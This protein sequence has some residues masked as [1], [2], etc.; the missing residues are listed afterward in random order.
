VNMVD[1]AIPDEP[2]FRPGFDKRPLDEQLELLPLNKIAGA[3]VS[4]RIL[5]VDP[6]GWGDLER[7][8]RKK[9]V[10]IHEHW[11]REMAVYQ[12]EV[13]YF[14]KML[15]GLRRPKSYV[16]R[17][18]EDAVEHIGA[19][20]THRESNRFLLGSLPKEVVPVVWRPQGDM[21][22]EYFRQ[23]QRTMM[24]PNSPVYTDPSESDGTFTMRAY[25]FP[26]GFEWVR[27]QLARSDNGYAS[28][29]NSI[30]AAIRFKTMQSSILKAIRAQVKRADK[31]P[32][33][34][35][36]REYGERLR[37]FNDACIT[38]IG[39]IAF[40]FLGEEP[41]HTNVFV[42]RT[43]SIVERDIE[44][45]PLV[46]IGKVKND[47]ENPGS[48]T[49]ELRMALTPTEW[50]YYA[51]AGRDTDLMGTP[52]ELK[53][54]DL[55]SYGILETSEASHRNLERK[56]LHEERHDTGEHIAFRGDQERLTEFVRREIK[57]R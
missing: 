12:A 18:L 25:A 44:V 13:E 50:L 19:I 22:D 53:V 15:V 17:P 33:G 10:T 9:L 49:Q 29:P 24:N 23:L 27:K 1:T 42:Q 8:P 40:Y 41:N 48:P 37:L 35:M 3:M 39:G 4:S 34:I 45:Q 47:Y 16:D 5:G 28:Y 30:A 38:D 21:K 6:T 51:V 36:K 56:R 7:M 32:K 43:C 54:T 55:R 46:T 2:I 26:E 14:F 20:T 11:Q 57:I 31:A 52:F